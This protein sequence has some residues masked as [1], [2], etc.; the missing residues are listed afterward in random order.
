MTSFVQLRAI[1][2][3]CQQFKQLHT[4]ARKLHFRRMPT[5]LLVSRCNLGKWYGVPPSCALYGA[6]AIGALV[7]LL[8]VWH[9]FIYRHECHTGGIRKVK[10]SLIKT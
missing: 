9:L 7:S 8:Y 1:E 3:I 5:L 6:F 2:C 10:R 4:I